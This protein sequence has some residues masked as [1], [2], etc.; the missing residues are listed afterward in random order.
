MSSNRGIGNKLMKTLYYEMKRKWL[1]LS[2]DN[3]MQDI[4][5]KRDRELLCIY[6]R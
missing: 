1:E 6:I 4:S 3:E 2:E 5:G